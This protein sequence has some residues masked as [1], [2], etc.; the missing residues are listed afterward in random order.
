[1]R[2]YIC[3]LKKQHA[4]AKNPE[5]CHLFLN[6]NMKMCKNILFEVQITNGIV[7]LSQAPWPW[8]CGIGSACRDWSL[9]VRRR[10]E[11]G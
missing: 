4:S 1:M 3:Q 5:K 2:L 6:H 8:S 11:S 10:I 9:Q 7:N